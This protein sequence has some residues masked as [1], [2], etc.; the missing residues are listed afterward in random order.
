MRNDFPPT[1]Q[2]IA[3]RDEL[4]QAINAQLDTYTSLMKNDVTA[5]NEAFKALALDYLIE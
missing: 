3:V 2:D 5:F 1:A 4:T